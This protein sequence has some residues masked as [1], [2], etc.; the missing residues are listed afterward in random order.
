VGQGHHRYGQRSDGWDRTEPRRGKYSRHQGCRSG[1]LDTCRLDADSGTKIAQ[2]V[3]TTAEWRAAQI[4]TKTEAEPSTD[5]NT[6]AENDIDAETGDHISANTNQMMGDNP[7]TKP[8]E[9]GH[10]CPSP[11]KKL[12]LGRPTRDAQETQEPVIPQ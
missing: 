11:N 7:T 2:G 3:P 1:V 6:D 12:E 10:P 8:K 9:T 4:E 5:T